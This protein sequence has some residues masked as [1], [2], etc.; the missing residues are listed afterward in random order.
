MHTQSGISLSGFM[1]W[2]VLLVFAALLGFKI[3]PPYF[4]Y[5]TI[6]SQFKAIAND[7]ESRG[8]L[9]RDIENAFVRRSTIEDIRSIKSGDLQITK[10][11]D[12]V[13]I[14]AEYTVCVHIVANMRAC[15]DY[16]PSSEKK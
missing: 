6:Q 15:M 13:V 5:L 3:G 16:Y 11:G 2:S 4:E 14:S 7:P 1:M 9:R 10:V 12:T 8:G